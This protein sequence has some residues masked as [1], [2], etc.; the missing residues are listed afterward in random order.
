MVPLQPVVATPVAGV[1]AQ[2]AALAQA[3]VMVAQAAGMV[4]QVPGG[5]T[6][7]AVVVAC[8]AQV[9]SLLVVHFNVTGQK[10]YYLVLETM[11]MKLIKF[12]SRSFIAIAIAMI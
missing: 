10:E 11:A 2:V 1:E 7:A 12:H 5:G 3:A 6:M 9:L 8:L 4:A